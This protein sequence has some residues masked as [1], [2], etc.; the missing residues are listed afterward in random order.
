MGRDLFN[1]NKPK[2]S[3]RSSSAFIFDPD[4][5]KI[6]V[7]SDRYYYRKMIGK[8]NYELVSM[9]DDQ[10]VS[11]KEADSVRT[12]LDRYAE[13]WYETAHYLLYKNKK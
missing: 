2:D 3:L 5:K 4:E 12:I 6:G 1:P 13:G 11:G 9:I 10:P 7:I 8:N